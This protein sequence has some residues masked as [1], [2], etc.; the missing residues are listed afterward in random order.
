MM[1]PFPYTDSTTPVITACKSKINA[2]SVVE[3]S[4]FLM[5]I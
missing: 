2:A 3:K 5:E 1:V 4:V